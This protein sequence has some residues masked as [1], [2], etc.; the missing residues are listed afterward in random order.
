MIILTQFSRQLIYCYS[1]GNSYFRA[2]YR[3]K[4]S[5]SAVKQYQNVGGEHNKRLNGIRMCKFLST[6]RVLETCSFWGRFQLEKKKVNKG[7]FLGYFEKKSRSKDE[8]DGIQI[9]NVLTSVTENVIFAELAYAEEEIQKTH[10]RPKKYQVE[11]PAKIKKE[12]GLYARYFGTALAIKQFTT[13]Y[14]KFFFVRTTV[15][16][17]KKK[18]NDGDW[19]VIKRIGKPNLLDCGMLKKVKDIALGTR[20]T[21]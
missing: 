13:K 4:E 11:I 1:N 14:P 18:C 5:R 21:G 20:M 7:K 17:W 12:I 15:K 19:T 9:T 8:T 16:T 3:Q 2:F 10:E 6:E